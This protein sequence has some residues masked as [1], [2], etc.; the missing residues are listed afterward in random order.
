M[1]EKKLLMLNPSHFEIPFILAARYLGFYVVT[2]STMS[3]YLGNQYANEYICESYNDYDK[4]IELC[5][6]EHIDAVSQGC[7]DDCALSAAYIGEAMGFK[8]HDTFENAK[9]IHHKDDFKKFAAKYGINTPIAHT[10]FD[11]LEA[12]AFCKNAVFP[13]IVKPNDLAGGQGISVARDPESYIQSVHDAF[14]RSKSK[15]IIVEPFVEGTLHS[16]STFII[17]QKVV[18]YG[19]ANDYSYLYPYMTTSGVLPADNWQQAVKE[20]IPETER[21]AQLLGLVDG[22][23]HMQYMMHNGKPT[24]IE[25]MR[26]NIGIQYMPCLV[27]SIG[28][29]WPQWCIRAEAGLDCSAMPPSR[30]PVDY[31]GY[32]SVMGPKNGI[33][34]GFTI[35]PEIQ[36][37]VYQTYE[38]VP[39]GHEITHYLSEKMGFVLLHFKTEAEKEKYMVN[40]YKYIRVNYK[41]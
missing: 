24:I 12:I 9:I 3:H 41:E 6:R 37:Y 30:E 14:N 23:L 2:T 29:D 31:Y 28:I 27:C 35:D 20:L 11:E 4:M 19:T 8:G 10:F 22:Q 33:Y 36:P 21:I 38:I 40:S 15:H 7:T 34:D 1:N 5:K 39:K 26:R 18:A 17:N 16:L 32:H 13:V 25:M